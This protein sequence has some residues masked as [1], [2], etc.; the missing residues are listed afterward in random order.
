MPTALLESEYSLDRL[1]F[2]PRAPQR[3]QLT[4][5]TSYTYIL[6]KRRHLTH[7]H[8]CSQ[9]PATK[10]AESMGFINEDLSTNVSQALHS[11]WLARN[12]QPN[13]WKVRMHDFL[14]L[15]ENIEWQSFRF[16]SSTCCLHREL[17]TLVAR[18]NQRLKPALGTGGLES[19]LAASNPHPRWGAPGPWQ[20][21]S[22][23]KGFCCRVRGCLTA[24]AFSVS[25]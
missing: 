10:F 11:D 18:W 19:S 22:D 24:T 9:S 23:L 1:C 5:S 16:R 25:L 20:W 13:Y 17:A 3:R 14:K 21:A 12:C 8:F 15:F 6:F 2:P 4:N 7:L